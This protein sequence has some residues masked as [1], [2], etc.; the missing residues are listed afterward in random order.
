MK[1]RTATPA[2]TSITAGEPAKWVRLGARLGYLA[3]GAGHV[4]S[5]SISPWIIAAS[6]PSRRRLPVNLQKPETILV[7]SLPMFRLMRL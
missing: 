3:K 5:A 2:E 1:A 4:L 7:K 6:R